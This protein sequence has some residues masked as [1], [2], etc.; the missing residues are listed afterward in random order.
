MKC[1][2]CGRWFED[3]HDSRCIYRTDSGSNKVTI[4]QVN[5]KNKDVK[6]T[7]HNRGS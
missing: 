3:Y 7:Q 5:Y 4:N 6:N 1:K 2:E